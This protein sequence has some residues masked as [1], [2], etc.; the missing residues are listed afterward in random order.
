MFGTAIAVL[1]VLSK[2]FMMIFA[3]PISFYLGFKAMQ[4]F[5]IAKYEKA[6]GFIRHFLYKNGIMKP[7][8]DFEEYPE[9]HFRDDED[10]YPSGYIREFTD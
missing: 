8:K 4:V 3:I 7:K 1:W 10:F 9:L 6:P 5:E 2:V